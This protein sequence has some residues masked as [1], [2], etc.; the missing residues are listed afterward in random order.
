[1]PAQHGFNFGERKALQDQ[2]PF[3]FMTI[4]AS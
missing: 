2:S 1:M 4:V 3:P